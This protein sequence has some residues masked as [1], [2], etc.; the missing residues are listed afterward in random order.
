M[1]PTGVVCWSASGSPPYN[2]FPSPFELVP[3]D[4]TN[5]GYLVLY[6]PA[7][8]VYSSQTTLNTAGAAVAPG[9]V[10]VIVPYSLGPLSVTAPAVGS[11]GGTAY[12]VDGVQRVLYRDYPQWL[13]KANT[14]LMMT[15][16]TEI[17]KSVQD[18]VYEGSLTYYGKA[19][20]WLTLGKSLNIARARGSTGWEAIAAAVRSVTLEWPQAGASTHTRLNFSTRRRA[21]AGDRLYLHPA[22][23]DK[24]QLGGREGQGWNPFGLTTAGMRAITQARQAQFERDYLTPPGTDGMDGDGYGDGDGTD[25][26]PGKR[27]RPSKREQARR[28]R[29]LNDAA[30]A[31]TSAET[32]RQRQRRE[33]QERVMSEAAGEATSAGPR[34]EAGEME[35]ADQAREA[36]RARAEGQGSLREAR[37]LDPR[38]AD[39]ASVDPENQIGAGMAEELLAGEKPGRRR[40]R[41]G[42]KRRARDRAAEGEDEEI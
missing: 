38:N 30:A 19:G 8:K 35:A 3:P 20:A 33:S 12:T 4:G 39:P 15:L 24:G 9:D 31:A 7:P 28:D 13:D 42:Q 32:A 22:Y 18:T 5:D 6:E 17:L 16:A 27:Y 23:G 36:R 2:E 21:F 10:K 29:A 37:G 14:A 40:A 1:T 11:Y 26:G 34:H 41:E 25:G